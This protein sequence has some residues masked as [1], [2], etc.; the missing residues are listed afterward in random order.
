MVAFKTDG[1]SN[2][3]VI[4][5]YV[6]MMYVHNF[7]FYFFCITKLRCLLLPI[8]FS[9][10]TSEVFTDHFI[11]K[12]VRLFVRLSVCS[13]VHSFVRWFPFRHWCQIYSITHRCGISLYLFI[14]DFTT[15]LIQNNKIL[16]FLCFISLISWYEKVSFLH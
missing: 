16:L 11:D 7:R 2:C 4:S 8:S 13:F 10:L 9:A 12:S 1:N 14:L 3:E 15:S 6:M 5:F